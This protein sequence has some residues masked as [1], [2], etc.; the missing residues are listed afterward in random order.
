MDNI[1]HETRVWKEFTMTNILTILQGQLKTRGDQIKTFIHN[2]Q[3]SIKYF[4]S[5]YPRRNFQAERERS[6]VPFHPII[7]QFPSISSVQEL[8]QA[9]LLAIKLAWYKDVLSSMSTIPNCAKNTL[10]T[11]KLTCRIVL[12]APSDPT[13]FLIPWLNKNDSTIALFDSSQS[14]QSS[15]ELKKAASKKRASMKWFA[16]TG[17]LWFAS[18]S[19]TTM[20]Q[21]LIF[22]IIFIR[23]SSWLGWKIMVHKKLDK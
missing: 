22:W 10:H 23:Q 13:M 16:K 18:T 14:I 20:M 4:A 12:L 1:I 21:G 11:L 5:N 3:Y 17:E 7:R 15:T 19:L 9:K 2:S 6:G 8:P